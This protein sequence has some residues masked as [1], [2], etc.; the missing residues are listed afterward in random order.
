MSL[1]DELIDRICIELNVHKISSKQKNA[2][3][4]SSVLRMII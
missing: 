1:V 3:V 2:V 4:A